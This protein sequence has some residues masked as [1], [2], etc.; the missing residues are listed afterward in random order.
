VFQGDAQLRVL[1]NEPRGVCAE[2]DL[3]APPLEFT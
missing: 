3:P 2:V 1:E